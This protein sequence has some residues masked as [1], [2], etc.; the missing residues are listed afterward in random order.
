[1]ILKVCPRLIKF[2]ASKTLVQ[3]LLLLW[4]FLLE[5]CDE[6]LWME[7][8]ICHTSYYKGQLWK[9]YKINNSKKKLFKDLLVVDIVTIVTCL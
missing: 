9:G 5:F 4:Q 1:M 3:R 7:E 2:C 6:K 8:R